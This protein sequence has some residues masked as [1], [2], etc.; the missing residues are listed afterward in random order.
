MGLKRKRLVET[1]V[2]FI[3]YSQKSYI[4]I[5]KE[6]NLIIFLEVTFMK[7]NFT[8][9]FEGKELTD[10]V[11]GIVKAGKV[12]S[13]DAR[14]RTKHDDQTRLERY[15]LEDVSKKL[16]EKEREVERL[17]NEIEMNKRVDK[18]K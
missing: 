14:K 3:F 2:S 9:D 7:L 17:K 15:Q 4:L 5:C 13:K 16:S 10:I 6:T 18:I 1:R 8:L 11:K 12:S